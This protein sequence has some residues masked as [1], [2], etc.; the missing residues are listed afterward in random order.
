MPDMQNLHSSPPTTRLVEQSTSSPAS[1]MK[2]LG[3]KRSDS[4][5]DFFLWTR[6]FLMSV[7]YEVNILPY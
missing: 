4:G 3:R 6:F 5:R 1:R 7:V 2:I